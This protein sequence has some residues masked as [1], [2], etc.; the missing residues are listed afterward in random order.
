MWK[1]SARQ[2]FVHRSGLLTLPC[3]VN[4]KATM[5][6]RSPPRISALLRLPALQGLFQGSQCLESPEVQTFLHS[7]W[8]P[9]AGWTLSSSQ[10]CTQSP[11]RAG[12]TADGL[13]KLLTWCLAKATHSHGGRRWEV[14]GT[15]ATDGLYLPAD[16]QSRLTA[17]VTTGVQSVSCHGYG[18]WL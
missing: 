8:L 15:L 6:S 9:G 1:A 13:G 10:G 11:W 12:S 4:D 14:R 17:C 5:R 3:S 2:I 18:A 7:P 16:Y